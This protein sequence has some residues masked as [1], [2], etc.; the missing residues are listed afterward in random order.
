MIDQ[1]QPVSPPRIAAFSDGG[2]ARL[3]GG[4]SIA[5]V[6]CLLAYLPLGLAL[7]VPGF[8][9]SFDP[10]GAGHFKAIMWAIC[11]SWPVWLC[12]NIALRTAVRIDQPSGAVEIT[13]T[14]YF[15]VSRTRRILRDDIADVQL[16][17]PDRATRYLKPLPRPVLVLTSGQ[18]IPLASQIY[19]SMSGR[20]DAR[21]AGEAGQLAANVRAMLVLS[22]DAAAA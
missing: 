3:A 1:L 16:V 22:G 8:A 7:T 6:T 21:R 19:E 14:N 20:V 15:L 12:A 10:G 9:D 2:P 13:T 5:A 18:M 4:A 17:V 11:L